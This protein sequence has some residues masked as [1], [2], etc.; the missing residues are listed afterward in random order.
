MDVRPEPKE[1]GRLGYN[2]VGHDQDALV[3]GPGV[4]TPSTV[5][6][7]PDVHRGPN[8]DPHSDSVLSGVQDPDGTGR[9]YY[10]HCTGVPQPLSKTHVADPPTR[11]T[12][13]CLYTPPSTASASLPHPCRSCST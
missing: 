1:S 8:R 9:R 12:P 11:T 3:Q 13:R 4:S 6:A 2:G 7:P 10:G 5:C